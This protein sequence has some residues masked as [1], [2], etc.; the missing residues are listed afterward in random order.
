MRLQSWL[1]EVD[2]SS[3][4]RHLINDMDDPNELAVFIASKSETADEDFGRTTRHLA[5]KRERT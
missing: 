3:A 1:S 5:P 2:P 4:I